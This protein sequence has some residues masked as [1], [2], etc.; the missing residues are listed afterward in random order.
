MDEMFKFIYA[1]SQPFTPLF[2]RDCLVTAKKEDREE[3][4]SLDFFDNEYEVDRFTAENSIYLYR[5]GKKLISLG[6][7]IPAYWREDLKNPDIREV[8]MYVSDEY[9]GMH[10]GRSMVW[11]M[12]DICLEKG[13]IPIAECLYENKA[14]KAT[15]ESIGYV[16]DITVRT[17]SE[18]SHQRV[19]A[20]AQ[21]N[22]QA[23]FVDILTDSGKTGFG[24][25][26]ILPQFLGN[27]IEEKIQKYIKENYGVHYSIANK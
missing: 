10:I 17:V 23:A 18:N 15:L 21:D 27:G 8:G 25:M 6:S 14:S 13:L 4:L 22:S 16:L 9:R 7:L 20:L 2:S 19:A 3:I 26:H 11:H 24:K 12:T 5:D 1:P